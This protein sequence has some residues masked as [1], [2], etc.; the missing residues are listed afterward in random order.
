MGLCGDE[1]VWKHVDPQPYARVPPC[2]LPSRSYPATSAGTARWLVAA[3][4]A[5]LCMSLLG[6]TAFL[7]DPHPILGCPPVPLRVKPLVSLHS[8]DCTRVP[9]T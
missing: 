5:P 9:R 4:Q 3:R 2:E 8:A 7:P 1:M 6:Y